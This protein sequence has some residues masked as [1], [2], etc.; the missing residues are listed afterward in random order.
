LNVK[1]EQAAPL[2]K[3]NDTAV[4]K[5]VQYKD[6]CNI[7]NLELGQRRTKSST[8]AGLDDEIKANYTTGKLEKLAGEHRSHTFKASPIKKV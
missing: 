1:T 7:P 5:I 4:A 3:G 6:I 2:E 8:S